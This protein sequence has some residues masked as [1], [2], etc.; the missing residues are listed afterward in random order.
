MKLNLKTL[1]LGRKFIVKK[2]FEVKNPDGSIHFFHIGDLL[3]LYRFNRSRIYCANLDIQHP[4]QHPLT[5]SFALDTS[6]VALHAENFL[7]ENGY[8]MGAVVAMREAV[9]D[10]EMVVVSTTQEEVKLMHV[11]TKKMM[12]TNMLT[13]VKSTKPTGKVLDLSSLAKTGDL[14]TD[15]KL[16]RG[17]TLVLKEAVENAPLPSGNDCTLPVGT[18]A[19]VI[20]S[21]ANIELMFD[22]KCEGNYVGLII[23]KAYAQQIFDPTPA[24]QDPL[25]SGLSIN[26]FKSRQGLNDAKF[27]FNL[28][29]DGKKVGT[30]ENSGDGGPSKIQLTSAAGNQKIE[31]IRSAVKLEQPSSFEDMFATYLHE[32]FSQLIPFQTFISKF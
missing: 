7:D 3:T 11:S 5:V 24:Y 22:Y 30:V 14:P 28:L 9:P 32:Q 2:A 20:K 6:V 31:Q 12:Q 8:V 27:S 13:L 4:K 1:R 23:N 26:A 18:R 29:L 25:F 15:L 19:V 16:G 10:S 17:E 21:G